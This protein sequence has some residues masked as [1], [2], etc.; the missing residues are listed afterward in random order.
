MHK[1]FR[2]FPALKYKNFQLYF[3]S[4]LISL[5]GTWV[6]IVT[7]G[8]L[9]FQLTHS[10]FW[11][12]AISAIGFLPIMLF[13]L[14]GGALVDRLPKKQVYIFTQVASMVLAF[15]LFLLAATNLINILNIAILAFLL[16]VINALDHPV[17]LAVMPELVSKEALPSAIALG[18]GLFNSARV[19]G[20]AFA[21]VLITT[22][23]I[24]GTF[25][26]NALSFIAPIIALSL[27]KFQPHPKQTHLHP[28]KSIQQGLHYCLTHPMIKAILIYVGITAIFGWSYVAIMPVI[29][30]KTFHTNASGLGF[31]HSAGG[32]G[33]VIAAIFVSAFSKRIKRE[34]LILVGSIIFSL[35]L[36]VFTLTS[37]FNLGMLFLLFSG[38]GLV[39]QN[40]T[41]NS[42][43]QHSVANFMR[44]RVMALYIM[45]FLGMGP[46]GSFLTGFLAEYFGTAFPLRLGAIIILIFGIN[47]YFKMQKISAVKHSQPLFS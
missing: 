37:N 44:G 21:G 40:A 41:L 5:T 32:L 9:V 46:I 14:F 7:Q 47:L 8:W 34:I 3:I 6:Q 39:M 36:F 45:M 24:S 20:P 43:V 16:G 19:I 42:I 23:S 29:A 28:L 30:E 31:L 25:L 11:V 12:G 10:A 13:A 27:I 1:F 35:S 26:I 15:I 33:A 17:R 18:A 38:I 22:F 4:Q 2:A